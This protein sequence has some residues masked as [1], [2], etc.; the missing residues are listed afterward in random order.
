LQQK[1]YTEWHASLII[2]TLLSAIDHLHSQGIMV[3]A[4]S[5]DNILVDELSEID[6]LKLLD[7]G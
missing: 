1:K 2:K 7:F 5:P 6:S 4:F 3:I